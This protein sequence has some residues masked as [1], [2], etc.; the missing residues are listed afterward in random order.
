MALRG[1]LRPGI[2]LAEAADIMWTYSS[3]GLYELLVTGRGWPPE[4]YG[5]FKRYGQ[6]IGQALVAA[7]LGAQDS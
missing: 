4:R 7:L 6:F 1:H 3:P 5:Q 2:T